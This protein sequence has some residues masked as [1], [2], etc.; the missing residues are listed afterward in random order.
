MG[1]QT[2]AT[3][4]GSS[5]EDLHNFVSC[6]RTGRRN[7]IPDIGDDPGANDPG[8]AGLAEK[9]SGLSGPSSASA[10]DQ[11]PS[12]ESSSKQAEKT[13]DTASKS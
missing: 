1:E 12:D 2:G 8:A 9:F 3:G 6:G 13:R 7:A 4:S 11:N 5:H 10:E